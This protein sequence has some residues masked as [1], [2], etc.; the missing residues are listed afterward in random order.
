MSLVTS[1]VV[2]IGGKESEI[3]FNLA[4]VPKEITYEA[5]KLLTE[6]KDNECSQESKA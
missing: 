2:K 1:F 5:S 6:R 4:L 3:F